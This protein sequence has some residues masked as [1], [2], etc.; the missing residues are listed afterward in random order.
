M[1]STKVFLTH[2]LSL[3]IFKCLPLFSSSLMLML[4]LEVGGAGTGTGVLNSAI[5]LP[6]PLSFAFLPL[7]SLPSSSL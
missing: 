4:M 3:I 1:R 6:P 2:C 5:S 7:C